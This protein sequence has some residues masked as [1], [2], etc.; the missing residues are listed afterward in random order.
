MHAVQSFTHAALHELSFSRH[1]LRQL[2]LVHAASHVARVDR[3]VPPHA[4]AVA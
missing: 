3:Q 2:G 4:R 1:V